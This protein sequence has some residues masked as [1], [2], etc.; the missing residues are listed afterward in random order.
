MYKL[1]QA[2]HVFK[3]GLN[4]LEIKGNSQLGVGGKYENAWLGKG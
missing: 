3:T 2:R 1:F 4:I